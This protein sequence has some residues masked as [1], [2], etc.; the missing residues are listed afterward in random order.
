MW[1]GSRRQ[2]VSDPCC[3]TFYHKQWTLILPRLVLLWRQLDAKAQAWFWDCTPSS[4][5]CSQHVDTT[6]ECCTQAALA[7]SVNWHVCS[8]SRPRGIDTDRLAENPCPPP[9]YFQLPWTILFPR[10]IPC[11]PPFFA[12]LLTSKVTL[13]P[14]DQW[15]HAQFFLKHLKALLAWLSEMYLD[16]TCMKTLSRRIE[17][18]SLSRSKSSPLSQTQFFLPVRNM[19]RLA[20]N[21]CPPPLYFQR[22][23]NLFLP[24]QLPCRLAN[25]LSLLWFSRLW[26]MMWLSVGPNSNIGPVW[27]SACVTFNAYLRLPS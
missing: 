16:L 7:R 4:H 24:P 2:S 9:L 20:E 10:H 6:S 17:F 15:Q 14:L 8:H 23:C 13:S 18:C 22:P 12:L 27:H 26:M 25:C 19:D 11:Q 21:H 3:G 5:Y 1:R